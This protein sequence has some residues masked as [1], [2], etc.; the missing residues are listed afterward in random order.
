MCADDLYFVT[1]L[2]DD[3]KLFSEIPLDYGLAVPALPP[4]QQQ[5]SYGSVEV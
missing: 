2:L 3:A 4:H 5:W 1:T